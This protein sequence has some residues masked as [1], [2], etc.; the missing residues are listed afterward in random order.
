MGTFLLPLVADSIPIV[1]RLAWTAVL[2]KPEDVLSFCLY[3][4]GAQHG[5]LF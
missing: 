5:N 4:C 2:R 3:Y 1:A